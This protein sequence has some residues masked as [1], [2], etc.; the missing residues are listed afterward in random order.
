MKDDVLAVNIGN[1][2]KRM[3]ESKEITITKLSTETGFSR[4]SIYGWE[5]GVSIPDLVSLKKISLALNVSLAELIEK[6]PDRAI[7]QDVQRKFEELEEMYNRL[8]DRQKDIASNMHNEGYSLPH[9]IRW[10]VQAIKEILEQ[11]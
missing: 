7:L 5:N 6:D 8:S 9:C 11:D 4:T 3:R 2:I 10:G 1:N